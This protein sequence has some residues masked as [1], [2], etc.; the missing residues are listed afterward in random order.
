LLVLKMAVPMLV[1]QSGSEPSRLPV[2]LDDSFVVAGL[3]GFSEFG[4]GILT[5]RVVD[6][7]CFSCVP[8]CVPVVGAGACC[9]STA[10]RAVLV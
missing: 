2:L 8:S 10:R 4:I 6:C 3:D 9:L 1:F 7:D 5:F